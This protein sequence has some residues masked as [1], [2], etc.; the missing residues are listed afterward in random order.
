MK[1]GIYSATAGMVTSV[2]R[3]NVISNNIANINTA[4]FKN[5]IPF[6]QVIR[7]LAE[8]PYP[9]KEQPLLA[10]TALDMS[11]GV[12]KTTGRPLDLAFEGPGMLAVR[13]ADGGTLFTRNGALGLNEKRRL[14]TAEGLEVLDK[15]NRPLTVYGESFYFTPGGELFID[16]NYAATLKVVASDPA[17]LEK[18]GNN[19]FRPRDGA[20]APAPLANPQLVVG[21]L[22]QANLNMM[23]ELVSMITVQRAFEFQNR[24]VE[25]ILSQVLRR[26]VS[27]LPRPL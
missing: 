21:A 12:I 27:D 11:N 19:F 17:S 13:A 1:C 25:T 22:E 18:V 2:E 16:G 10:G 6:E 24:A 15:N 4:G 8:G 14:V 20:A 26:T 23:Q 7:F 5:D 9:G 3:L